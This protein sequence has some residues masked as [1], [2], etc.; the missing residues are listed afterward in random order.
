MLT[1]PLS[2]ALAEDNVT[3]ITKEIIKKSVFTKGSSIFLLVGLIIMIFILGYSKVPF[4]QANISLDKADLQRAFWY[5]V[6]FMTIGA[7]LFFL[8]EIIQ[9]FRDIK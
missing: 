5:D 7:A 6:L 4:I 9:K 3:S 8:P 2:L 1:S